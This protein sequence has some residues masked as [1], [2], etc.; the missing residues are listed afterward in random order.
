MALVT[1]L[2]VARQAALKIFAQ[3]TW[4]KFGEAAIANCNGTIRGV[5]ANFAAIKLVGWMAP[6]RHQFAALQH[7]T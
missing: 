4:M 5:L 6:G 2:A 7:P 1:H 3:I